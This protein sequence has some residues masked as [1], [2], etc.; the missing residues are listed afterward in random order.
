MRQLLF[1]VTRFIGHLRNI[2]MNA[3]TT[4]IDAAKLKTTGNLTSCVYWYS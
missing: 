3:V 2:R 4:N 1:V